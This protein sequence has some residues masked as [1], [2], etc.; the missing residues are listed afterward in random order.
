GSFILVTGPCAENVSISG[1]NALNL[2]AYYGQPATLNGAIY[3]NNSDN[4]FLYGLNVTNTAGNGIAI[5][6]SRSIS[7]NVCSSSGNAGMG[8]SVN[9]MSDVTIGDS[10]AFDRNG[11]G[12]ININGNS[13]V[14]LVAWAGP[15]DVSNNS[16]P[17]V[18]AST[19]SV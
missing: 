13:L 10:G 11:N 5:S 3:I 9:G 6:N 17:G 8:L 2:G 16:G 7:L 12:G 18:W 1:I 15:V 4:I 14:A 19:S